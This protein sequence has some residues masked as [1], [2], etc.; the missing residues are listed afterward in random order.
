M[1]IV[2]RSILYSISQVFLYYTNIITY[3]NY[4]CVMYNIYFI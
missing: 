3:N 4:L 1:L 2:G